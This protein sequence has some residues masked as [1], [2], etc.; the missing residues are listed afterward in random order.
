MNTT[1]ADSPGGTRRRI[2]GVIAVIAILGI[3]FVAGN[4]PQGAMIEIPGGV[5]VE[6]RY[7]ENTGWFEV[8]EN[9]VMRAEFTATELLIEDVPDPEGWRATG[10]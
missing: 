6:F 2:V 9:G 10:K 8:W 1:R 7:D 5:R 4:R 3:G